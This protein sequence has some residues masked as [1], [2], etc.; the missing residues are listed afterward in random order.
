MDDRH[1]YHYF[2][3]WVD[4][5]WGLIPRSEA[6]LNNQRNEISGIRQDLSTLNTSLNN[7]QTQLSGI[8][9][10][11]NPLQTQVSGLSSSVSSLQAQVAVVSSSILNHTS[12][13]TI[14]I[15]SVEASI[16][17]V[18][19]TGTN[20]K[21]SGSGSIID[22]RGYVLTNQHVIDGASTIKVTLKDMSI[23]DGTVI[24]SDS[25]RDLALIKVTTNRT[26]FPII[27]L[28][29]VSDVTV[30]E[31]VI[32]AGFPLGPSLSGPVTF[33]KGIVSAVRTLDDGLSYLQTD[34][35][36]NPGTSGGC[37]IKL[38]GRM[39]GV[40]TA[41]LAPVRLDIEDINVAV[42][43]GDIRTFVQKNLS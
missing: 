14:T 24:A 36:I 37:L 35:P 17:R 42:P 43:I 5:Q 9:S 3:N 28:G 12:A 32:V 21:A 29:Q 22:K 40:P 30:G 41:T 38:D 20:L 6:E 26:D 25:N 18:N 39:I 4:N 13:V 23:Y 31:D 15:A 8:S 11:G 27:T 16:V 33:T 7:L 2:G 19:V 10:S 1:N 34:A